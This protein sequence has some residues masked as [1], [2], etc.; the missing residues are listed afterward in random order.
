[1]NK[2]ASTIT[3]FTTTRWHKMLNRVNTRASYLRKGIQV[4]FSRAEFHSWVSLN[5]TAIQALYAKNKIP[6]I[7]RIDN[8]GHYSLENIQI[9]DYRLNCLKGCRDTQQ[10]K[11]IENPPKPCMTCSVLIDRNLRPNGKLETWADF[12]QRKTCSPKCQVKLKQRD[13][14]GKFKQG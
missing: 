2:Q 4:T 3:G 11:R 13:S 7:D 14:H 5:W 9:L 6:S 8:N 12:K 10:R 1:M